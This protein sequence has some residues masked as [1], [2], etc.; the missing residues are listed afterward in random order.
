[1][2][3]P[4]FLKVTSGHKMRVHLTFKDSSVNKSFKDSLLFPFKINS[5]TTV[6]QR[7]K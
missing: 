2:T 5:Y 1:M 4:E 6:N 7:R 3:V